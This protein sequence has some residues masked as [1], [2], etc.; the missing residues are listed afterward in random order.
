MAKEWNIDQDDDWF[1]GEKKV[2]QFQIFQADGVTPQ[3]ITG[4][5]FAYAV[6]QAAREAPDLLRKAS[7]SGIAVTVPL[8]GIGQITVDAA[9]TLQITEGNYEHGLMRSDS[10]S[11]AQLLFGYAY[12]NKGTV[13]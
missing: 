5:N 7:G 12:L 1:I 2:L 10:G 9:D 6:K 8:T 3:D 13:V 4:W 11:E